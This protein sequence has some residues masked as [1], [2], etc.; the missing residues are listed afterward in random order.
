MQ[1]SVGR[2][3]NNRG[4]LCLQ[5]Y[6]GLK[7]TFGQFFKPRKVQCIPLF[8]SVKHLMLVSLMIVPSSARHHL[9]LCTEGSFTPYIGG[10]GYGTCYQQEYGMQIIFWSDLDVSVDRVFLTRLKNG[11]V[12]KHY[13]ELKPWRCV[14]LKPGDTL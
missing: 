2:G 7:T 6:M 4:G 3:E 13:A 11:L 5:W 9:E 10:D 14:E 8:F 1:A 12:Q